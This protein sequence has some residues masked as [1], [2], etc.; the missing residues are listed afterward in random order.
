LQENWNLSMFTSVFIWYTDRMKTVS[1]G[2]SKIG[3][4][5]K[6]V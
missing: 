3:I 5:R 1:W 6:I 4:V 2:K